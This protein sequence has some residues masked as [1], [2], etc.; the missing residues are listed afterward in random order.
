[1]GKWGGYLL[2]MLNLGRFCVTFSRPLSLLP[3]CNLSPPPRYNV[4]KSGLFYS[5]VL[6]PHTR[7]PSSPSDTPG[8]Q[9]CGD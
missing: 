6:I 9:P 4:L 5:R 1:M 7:C 2:F 3:L 8:Q